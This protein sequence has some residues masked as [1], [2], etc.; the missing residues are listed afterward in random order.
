MKIIMNNFNS[1]YVESIIKKA[2]D[3]SVTIRQN[4]ESVDNTWEKPKRLVDKNGSLS[5]N[6]IEDVLSTKDRNN[7]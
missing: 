2:L 3:E 5:L 6:T 4:S 1:S 7:M